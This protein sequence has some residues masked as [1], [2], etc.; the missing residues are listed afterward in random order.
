[1]WS[2][3]K[4]ASIWLLLA[5]VG[6]RV[7]A[8]PDNDDFANREVIQGIDTA[9]TLSL[10]NVTREPNEPI[11][12]GFQGG[13]AWYA[14]T[15][16]ADGV[17]TLEAASGFS[18]T[19]SVFEGI[20]RSNLSLLGSLTHPN[21]PFSTPVRGGVSYSLALSAWP[22][23][24]ATVRMTFAQYFTLEGI[25]PGASFR[26]PVALHLHPLG[27]PLNETFT[28]FSVYAN[29]LGMLAQSAAPMD[30]DLPAV[31]AGVYELLGDATATSGKRYALKPI[32]FSVFLPNDAFAN[33]YTL[34]GA[35][36][37]FD[38]DI[39]GSTLD[40]GELAAFEG[41]AWFKWT[42]PISG[43]VDFETIS[44]SGVGLG[45]Y[46][47][48]SAP[49]LSVIPGN[50]VVAGH[51]YVIRA[52]PAAGQGF[53]R[54]RL[55]VIPIPVPNDSFAARATI[56]NTNTNF[57]ERL[58]IGLATAEPGEPGVVD[59]QGVPS[60]WYDFT[61][62]V[63]GTVEFGG[64]LDGSWFIPYLYPPNAF[65][66]DSLASLVAVP[67]SDG[68]SL[69]Q[70]QPGQQYHFRVHQA[71]PGNSSDT[72]RTV[73]RSHPA[74]AN[75]S[76]KSP[77][78][79]ADDHTIVL[80]SLD[81]AATDPSE[82][83]TKYGSV[84][85]RSLWWQWTATRQG[86]FSFRAPETSKDP[87]ARRP[88][89]E[90]FE[91]DGLGSLNPTPLI[92]LE[93][94]ARFFHTEIGK[95]YL[96][97]M[98]DMAGEN[99]MGSTPIELHFDWSDIEIATPLQAEAF[100]L[101]LLP[102][103]TIRGTAANAPG[104]RIEYREQVGWGG[105]PWLNDAILVEP[106]GPGGE[107]EGRPFQPT[108]L[109]PGDHTF[110]ACATG[111]GGELSYTPPV[112]FRLRPSNDSFSTEESLTG[113]HLVVRGST[114][115][116]TVEAGEPWAS[117]QTANRSVWY[118]WTAPANGDVTLKLFSET[119]VRAFTGDSLQTL[120]PARATGAT[121]GTDTFNAK[122][123]TTY[124]IAVGGMQ[125]P[126]PAPLVA[127]FSMALDQTTTTWI[128]PQ[129]ITNTVG[130][131]V[132]LALSTTELAED[133]TRFSLVS[134]KTLLFSTNQPPLTFSWTPPEPGIYSVVGLV[135]TAQ[136]ETITNT[137]RSIKV[138]ATN[139]TFSQAQPVLDAQGTLQGDLRAADR[140]TGSQLASAWFRFIAP[141]N[142]YLILRTANGVP[143]SITAQ[144]STGAVSNQQVV[145]TPLGN[146]LQRG[147]IACRVT[148]AVAY[149]IK[150]SGSPGFQ[151]TPLAYE[152][153]TRPANDNFQDASPLPVPLAKGRTVTLS[154]TAEAGEPN[155]TSKPATRS[156]WWTWTAP[157][158]GVLYLTPGTIAVYSGDTL[159]TLQR[160]P[161]TG[162]LWVQP[163]QVLRLALDETSGAVPDVSWTV[164]FE[165]SPANDMF[166][167][168]GLVEG[169]RARFDASLS[170]ATTEPGESGPEGYNY[171][172]TVWYAW[173]APF[174]A[175]TS[176]NRAP[177]YPYARMAVFQG[178]SVDAL[179]LVNYGVEPFL[180]DAVAGQ[181]YQISIDHNGGG[182]A[183]TA[184]ELI[185]LAPP[186]NDSFA[187]RETLSGWLATAHGWNFAT[188]RDRAE[189][190]HA[191][192]TGGRSVWYRW[193]APQSGP[194]TI[195]VD[196]DISTTL[197]AVYTHT[198][199][200][201][202]TLVPVASGTGVNQ[203]TASF[204]AVGGTEYA[205]AVD[206]ANG[207]AGDFTLTLNE[208]LPPP[209][210]WLS[211][212]TAPDG[213]TI[214]IVI[215]ALGLGQRPADLEV[216]ADLIKWS[217]LDSLPAGSNAH[218]WRLDPR[219]Q[220][221]T[222]TPSRFYRLRLGVP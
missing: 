92:P 167:D 44:G 107:S 131:P 163:G 153:V 108:S 13:S 20:Q 192:I 33:A 115:A 196:G 120:V 206:G 9:F 162:S 122:R 14:W 96:M 173:T 186:G 135:E 49:T 176:L 86:W 84:P 8:Q 132:T 207:A 154:A 202:D 94:E 130:T 5:L 215:R 119:Y 55:F 43:M 168:R 58:Y 68:F 141:T 73:L 59:G 15:A 199:G 138:R 35:P 214:M 95:T 182:P 137:S 171:G 77:I 159:P 105:W 79:L 11:E 41:S 74:P 143:T 166:A 213:G 134:G 195:S 30:L 113:R 89:L 87:F 31:T 148:N 109:A 4:W 156:V 190:A 1:M 18:A 106:R 144:I 184:L 63:D 142:G 151:L 222:Q 220:P 170:L 7:V 97:R 179:T 177:G 126:A 112:T 22:S 145:I 19:A 51:R 17:I 40:P 75:R 62:S 187:S 78:V 3:R 98:S 110:Y 85:I 76:W 42:A 93:L 129:A 133:I 71:F 10:L 91:T 208:F 102:T 104:N 39:R 2:A 27:F 61:P 103:L 67:S 172:N 100:Q 193:I 60:A 52:G 185:Q 178:T 114:A 80:A 147:W 174:T 28:N 183:G 127:S 46:E 136:G 169:R 219:S 210:P 29:G 45:L 211:V 24:P 149:N 121:S 161:S 209:P 16:P 37:E 66:G 164:R 157:A 181:T 32:A 146:L 194:V 189:P 201:V 99:G 65:T 118:R 200:K 212:E 197:L 72:I 217:L 54:Y 53:G 50:R 6:L 218:E 175:P 216:S 123:G 70:V 158:R 47:G 165:P 188:H 117:S 116:A 140:D 128:T 124:H 88:V 64:T 203:A 69:F 221:Q 38:A 82:P 83:I 101:P 25:T 81:G 21:I 34:V 36:V 111:P 57:T 90:V 48:D 155:H 12:E 125:D 191:G 152:F 160:I 26:Q 150:F 139:L 56:P 23:D 205:I 180:F 204:Q 198:G